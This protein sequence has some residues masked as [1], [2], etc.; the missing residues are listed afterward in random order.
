MDIFSL[1]LAIASAKSM[2]GTA[3]DRAEAAQTAAETAQGK[4]ED[5]QAAA[6]AAAA[7]LTVDSALDEDS[8]NPVQNKII[9]ETLGALGLRVT[10]GKLCA[11]W[12][13][14]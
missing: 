8:T 9:T 4:A 6:E 14:N 10:N 5:A 13:E 7:T 11:V 2:P 1:I 3:A 12:K